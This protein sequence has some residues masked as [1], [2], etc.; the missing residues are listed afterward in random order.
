MRYSKAGT[1]RAHRSASNSPAS[2]RAL[3]PGQGAGLPRAPGQVQDPRSPR[4]TT[5]P[6]PRRRTRG[7]F[8]RPRPPPWCHTRPKGGVGPGSTRPTARPAP[9]SPWPLAAPRGAAGLPVP[10][11]RRPAGNPEKRRIPVS[12]RAADRPSFPTEPAGNR[13]KASGT[14]LCGHYPPGT[15]RNAAGREMIHGTYGEKREILRQ[16]S[17]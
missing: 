7:T 15:G 2:R 4:N 10:E 13:K 17:S 1:K 11:I 6:A 9:G 12:P 8:P 5:T 3:R 16:L 14:G